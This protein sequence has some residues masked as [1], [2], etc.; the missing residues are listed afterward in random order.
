VAR[1]EDTCSAFLS[2]ALSVALFSAPA[3]AQT[4]TVTPARDAAAHAA[5]KREAASFGMIAFVK[6]EAGSARSASPWWTRD[7]LG[8]TPL[9]I[10]MWT[11]RIG[12]TP[13]GLTL[14]SVGLGAGG[15]GRGSR[16][17]GVGTVGQGNGVEDL[18]G[19]D[20]RGRLGE[21]QAK[22]PPLQQLPADAI[23]RIVRQ[24][25]GAIRLCY[26]RGLRVDA[27][28]RGRVAVKFTIAHDGTV[29]VAADRDSDLPDPE[30]VSCVVRAF[31]N[32]G[33]PRSTGS[34]VTVVYPLIFSPEET[35]NQ[36]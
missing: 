12:E 1:L 21:A 29:P 25:F 34:A 7:D 17:E 3:G 36:P 20:G 10:A 35:D 15:S 8:P 33:F 4:S 26:D 27:N 16:Q 5:E 24:S 22:P 2:A 31:L 32:L 9:S 23:Q 14:S 19:F 13:G 6:G 18:D 30:V 11:P 28:L